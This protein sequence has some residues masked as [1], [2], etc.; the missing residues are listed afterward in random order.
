MGEGGH[1]PPHPAAAQL[2]T[3]RVEGFMG[4]RPRRQQVVQLQL[5]PVKQ[6]VMPHRTDLQVRWGIV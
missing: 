4:R 5:Q 6:A 3:E 2:A 1:R